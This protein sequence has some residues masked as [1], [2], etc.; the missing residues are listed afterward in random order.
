VQAGG[1]PCAALQLTALASARRDEGS[2]VFAGSGA[3]RA[4]T[5]RLISHFH[6]IQ[7]VEAAWQSVGEFWDEIL[8][9]TQVQT[10]DPQHGLIA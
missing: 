9:Q 10:P 6:N 8:E 1:D 3:D 7:N 4:D 2:H 5:E